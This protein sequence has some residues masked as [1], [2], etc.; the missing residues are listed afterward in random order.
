[1]EQ[2]VARRAHNPK[3]AG[4]SPVP[5]T[6]S[7]MHESASGF[8]FGHIGVSTDATLGAQGAGRDVVNCIGPDFERH[9]IEQGLDEACD[10]GDG[11]RG[12]GVHQRLGAAAHG[13]TSMERA[14]PRSHPERLC[15]AHGAREEP[16]PRK[17]PDVRLLG[18]VRFDLRA[19]RVPRPNLRR[20]HLPL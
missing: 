11:A 15:A 2:L 19:K 8:S 14:K 10:V 17:H 16:V 6:T 3:V 5:A 12:D 20:L 7:P 18:G 13:G 4:S 9:G 1:M